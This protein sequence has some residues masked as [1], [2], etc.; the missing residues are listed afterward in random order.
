MLAGRQQ[1][2]AM[3]IEKNREAQEESQ[4]RREELIKE[5][6]TER[7]L[8]RQE[9]ESQKS[10]RTAW[11][12]EVDAQVGSGCSVLRTLLRTMKIPFL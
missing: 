5:L 7:N 11:L 1:Q 8:R 2:L 3:K 6:E 9:R 10:R 12:E 4:R